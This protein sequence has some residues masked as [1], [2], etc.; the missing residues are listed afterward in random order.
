MKTMARRRYK[1]TTP[2][3]ESIGQRLRR[4]IDAKA[5]GRTDAEIAE[6]AGMNAAVISKITRGLTPNPGINTILGI[7]EVLPATMADLDRA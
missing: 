6:A 3:P 4:L 2:D 7:L 5:K 1:K